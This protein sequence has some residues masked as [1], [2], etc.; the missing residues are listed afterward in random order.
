MF[1][2]QWTLWSAKVLPQVEKLKAEYLGITGNTS[3]RG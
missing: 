1:D 3:R 2:I